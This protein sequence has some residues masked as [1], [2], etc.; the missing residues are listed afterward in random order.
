MSRTAAVIGVDG[1]A[2]AVRAWIVET[3]HAGS[4]PSAGKL[5]VRGPPASEVYARAPG[6]VPLPL[7]EQIA[8]LQPE[9][10]A[11]VAGRLASQTATPISDLRASDSYRRHTVGVMASRALMAAAHRAAGETIAVPVNR[12]NGVEGS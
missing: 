11:K 6:F 2:T 5:V 9:D 10:A 4:S 8:G 1:G 3:A 7:A 12:A